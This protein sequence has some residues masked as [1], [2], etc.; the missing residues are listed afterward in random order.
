MKALIIGYGSAGSRHHK[1]LIKRGFSCRIVSKKIRKIG[2]SFRTIRDG[3]TVFKPHFVVISNKTS[4][5]EK[6][7]KS[8]ILNKFKGYVLCEKPLSCHSKYLKLNKFKHFGVNYNLRFY[9]ILQYLKKIIQ[10][11]KVLSVV[12]YCGQYLP[13]WRKTDYKNS[14]SAKKALGGGVLKDLSHELDM[15][16][17]LFGEWVKVVALGGKISKLKIDSEDSFSILAENKK[18]P[19]CSI[20]INYLDKNY[21]RYINVCCAEKTIHVDLK[22][23]I[24]TVNKKNRLFG[25]DRDKSFYDVHSAILTKNSNLCTQKEAF[26][27]DRIISLI[28]KSA[29]K[30]KWIYA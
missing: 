29:K 7:I 26:K 24:L 8:L 2:I 1:L 17:W 3:I 19:I 20:N 27:T 4:E 25:I 13:H 16:R 5:H 22:N 15:C 10:G 23:G 14:Y 18:C 30:N 6:T 11:S 12:C 28:K 9:P 21:Q